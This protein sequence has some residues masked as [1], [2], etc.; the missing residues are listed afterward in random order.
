MAD[1]RQNPDEKNRKKFLIL[2][3]D[4]GGIRG[5]IP[6]TV[7]VRLESLIREKRKD[8]GSI[9]E[10]FDLIAGTSTG[11]ILACLYL[12]P[13][14][15][16][17]PCK[18]RFEAAK[19]RDFYLE[20]GEEIFQRSLWQRITAS[21]GILDEKYN[22]GQLE[23]HL[24]TYLGD[25][26]L[27]DLMKPCLITGYNVRQYRPIFFTK[28]DADNPATNYKVRDV[29]RAT[30]AAPTYFEAA[31]PES[32][33]NIRDEFPVIDGGVFANNPTACALVEAIKK[34]R[35]KVDDGNFMGVPFEDIVILS[36][37]TGR[38]STTITYKE[39]KNWG[40][41]G[42]AR[43]LVGIIMEGV[44]QTVDYQMQNIFES[45]NK[46]EDYLRIDGEFDDFRNGLAVDGLDSSLDCATYE[47][48]QKLVTFGEL[49]TQ[50]FE[51]DLKK[52]VNKFF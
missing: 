19:I 1:G 51:G 49:L 15:K 14:S 38:K 16:E 3:I 50:K 44:S 2:S 9:G 34:G 40:L 52:F 6:A 17:N 18:A 46:K 12:T 22:A 42:W 41:I 48:M 23:D 8:N 36:L 28:Q 21:G 24:K 29:A 39:C 25:L 20:H 35:G 11:G 47:N 30:A 4:G 13:E 26:E 43:P 10:Y 7:L 32:L 5:L 27:K 45:Q 37:G 33:D 31:L